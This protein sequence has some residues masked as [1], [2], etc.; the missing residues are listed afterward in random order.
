[1]HVGVVGFHTGSLHA[2]EGIFSGLE[3]TPAFASLAIRWFPIPL[4]FVPQGPQDRLNT[5]RVV[6]NLV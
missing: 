2:E 4:H 5:N 1:M 3:Q 6:L